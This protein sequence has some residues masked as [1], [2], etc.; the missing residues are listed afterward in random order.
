M[1]QPT[2]ILHQEVDHKKLT[3]ACPYCGSWLI[4]AKITVFEPPKVI[5][6]LVCKNCGATGP[7]NNIEG[8]VGIIEAIHT[9]N[10]R[11][12]YAADEQPWLTPAK[13]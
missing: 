5:T 9:W 8:V 1:Q 3:E 4:F 2:S 11:P 12:P 7:K 13:K 6:A 10:R